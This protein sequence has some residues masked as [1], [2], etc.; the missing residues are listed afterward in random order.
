[1][2][3][4]KNSLYYIVVV[5]LLAYVLMMAF[6]PDKLMD[7]IGFRSFIITSDSMDPVLEVN[8]LV[9]IKFVEPEELEVGD[10]ITFK[11]YLS[12]IGR[13][14]YVTHNLIDID[15]VN[16]ETVY[17]TQ[18]ER[19]Y[20]D[21]VD[22]WYTADGEPIYITDD[23]LE[24]RYLFKI[25]KLGYIRYL[26]T[27]PIFLGLIVVNGFIVFALFRFLRRNKEEFEESNEENVDN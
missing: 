8:D 11:T 22:S 10:I 5:L 26:I 1:M 9:I 7:Y 23:L 4:I 14:G 17:V 19:H 3:T 20:S 27:E 16:G 15:E 6:K 21:L 13:Y 12:E 2:Q 18:G 25:P 24:G